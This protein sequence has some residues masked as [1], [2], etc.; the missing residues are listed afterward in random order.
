MKLKTGKARAIKI[1]W[2]IL[3]VLWMGLIF[4]FSG[5]RAQVSSELSGSISYRMAVRAEEWF[6]FGWEEDALL[7]YAKAWERP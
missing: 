6:S 4:R 3:A 1:L 5:Q 7:Q 2:L